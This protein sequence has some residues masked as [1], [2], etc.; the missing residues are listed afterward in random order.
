MKKGSHELA[1]SVE[2][3]EEIAPI[4]SPTIV[5]AAMAAAQQKSRE[6]AEARRIIDNN[7]AGG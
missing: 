1:D 4:L 3:E 6:R 2:P 5:S 7:N